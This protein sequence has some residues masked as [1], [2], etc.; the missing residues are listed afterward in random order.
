MCK[1][2]PYSE[3]GHYFKMDQVKGLDIGASYLNRKKAM[4]FSISITECE[5]EDLQSLFQKCKFFSIVVDE[6]TDVY[7]LEQCVVFIRFNIRG[8]IYTKFPD[9]NSVVHPNAEQITDSIMSML[10]RTV[11]WI[12]PDVE[13]VLS[14]DLF[15]QNQNENDVVELA[16]DP[17]NEN[18]NLLIVD[19][20]VEDEMMEGRNENAD[21]PDDQPSPEKFHEY[22]EVIESLNVKNTSEEVNLS[23]PLLVSVTSDGANVLKG[24]RTGVSARL[25]STCNKLLLHSHCVSH[26]CELEL[27]STAKRQCELCKDVNDFLE[28]LFT[29]HIASN[30]VT[31]TFRQTV[32]ELS[33]RCISCNSS[34]R[35]EVDFPYIK[36]DEKRP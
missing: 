28:S 24:R 3:Y 12:P 29:F 30:V 36:C 11:E 14:D 26:R 19:Q 4:E 2:R 9:I 21:G 1:G 13:N 34:E 7:R 16:E 8:E 15:E 32:E 31:N 22:T 25:R 35:N 6:S 5:M 20:S 27:K 33:I 10:N 18:E 17:N 23:P